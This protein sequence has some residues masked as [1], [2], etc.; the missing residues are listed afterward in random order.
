MRKSATMVS[1]TSSAMALY[2]ALFLALA[3]AKS[4]PLVTSD[5][6]QAAAAKRL[7]LEVELV[8]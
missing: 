2:D 6:I 4:I 3:R 5:P 8:P 7:N 1:A